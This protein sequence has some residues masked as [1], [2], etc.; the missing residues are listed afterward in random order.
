MA[1]I[2]L[3]LLGE[4]H[5]GHVDALL[6]DPDV[7]RFTRVPE[8]PP[9]GFAKHWLEMYE[10]ARRDGSREAFAVFGEDERFAGVALAPE[11]DRAGKQLELGYIVAAEARG[12][13]VGTAILRA[14]TRWAFEDAGAERAFLLIDVDNAASLRVAE[15][16]G[17]VQEGVIRSMH[18]KQGRRADVTLW[19]RLPSDPEP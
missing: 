1:S 17:Y 11:I 15:R 16:S 2:R 6:Y 7:L 9:V 18:V 8:P 19:S 13:G 14:L 3:E 10:V 12:R 5:L 4:E